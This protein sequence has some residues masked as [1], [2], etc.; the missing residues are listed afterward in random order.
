MSS[1]PGPPD[2]AALAVAARGV[3]VS[4]VRI[5]PSVHGDGDHG[6]VSA[7]IN[8]ARQKGVSAYVGDG[9]NR[10]AAVYRLDAAQLFRLALEKGVAGARYHGVGDEGVPFRSIAELI[11]RR[12][13]VPVASKSPEEAADHFGFFARFASLDTPAS[14][15]RTQEQLGWKPTHPGLLEDLDHEYYFKTKAVA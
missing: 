6:F 9:R 10:W 4:V 1:S 5:P 14:S 12:L 7:L 13:N 2:L 15:A 3:R 11:G 8:I